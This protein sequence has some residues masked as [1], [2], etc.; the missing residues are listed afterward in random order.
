MRGKDAASVC[1]RW[2]DDP[3]APAMTVR[4][5]DVLKNYPL[6]Y[7]TLTDSLKRRYSNFLENEDYHS[8][9]KELQKYN[10]YSIERVLNPNNPKSSRQRFF[11]PNILQEFDRIYVRR[12]KSGASSEKAAAVNAS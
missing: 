2:T 7:R 6:T 8:A 4:E 1:F 3:N 12:N 11:N 5:E 9:R 10:K